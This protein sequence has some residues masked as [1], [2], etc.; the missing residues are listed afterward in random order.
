MATAD[1]ISVSDIFE[2]KYHFR[3]PSYQRGYRWEKNHIIKLVE[4]LTKFKNQVAVKNYC[5]QPIILKDVEGKYILVDGQQRLTSLWILRGLHYALNERKS[6]EW[7]NIE[8]TFEGKQVYTDLFEKVKTVFCDKRNHD[9]DDV[10]DAIKD[11][12]QGD[13]SNGNNPDADCFFNNLIAVLELEINEVEIDEILRDIFKRET[14]ASK[15]SVLDRIKI[16]KY[17]LDE[18]EDEIE[19]FTNINA[20]KIPLTEAELIKA[21]F[22]YK[23]THRD[24]KKPENLDRQN[25]G[26][27]WYFLNA[28]HSC[29][30]GTRIDLLFQI[31]CAQNDIEL[32]IDNS[33]YPM[34][35]AIE[36]YIS[37]RENGKN[38]ADI[39]EDIW[40]KIRETENT[41]YDWYDDYFYYHAIG[42]LILLRATGNQKIKLAAADTLKELC[43]KYNKAKSKE[44]FKKIVLCDLRDAYFKNL[45]SSATK[46][47]L[48]KRLGEINYRENHLEVYSTLL[49]YN[50]A[51]LVNSKCEYESFQFA[52]FVNINNDIEHLNPQ[53]ESLE[54]GSNQKT[55]IKNS[56][57]VYCEDETL[58]ND[59][60][61]LAPEEIKEYSKQL[62][63]LE[64]KYQTHS[65]GNLV[66][67]DGNTNR[68]GE[69]KKERFA[70][71][72]QIIKDILRT[73]K[74]MNGE[75]KDEAVYIPIGTKWVFL[76]SFAKQEES[77]I[78]DTRQTVDN[79][80]HWCGHAIY[81]KDI[82]E[83]IAEFLNLK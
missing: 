24:E 58:E 10:K 80:G 5:L 83:N 54:T 62:E 6:K 49:T 69:Y 67:L 15:E 78:I 48:I 68:S 75:G 57:D 77:E 82:A 1:K 9:I 71:K 7:Q 47:A 2:N 4:D 21:H 55:I 50:I 61:A 33:D 29:E 64:A 19:A 66:L 18:N 16:I 23:F 74:R 45:K 44:D 11:L 59:G 14:D 20:N 30:S 42:L 36:N 3:V 70:K 72:A 65:L 39:A 28:D 13:F 31:W 46:E 17:E 43:V 37:D 56:L 52:K 73:G 34:F 53:I 51:S 22:L 26:N 63:S 12:R 81:L 79:D 8:I 60:K 38:E 76:N 35:D 32:D 41:L 25:F 27:Q 40:K